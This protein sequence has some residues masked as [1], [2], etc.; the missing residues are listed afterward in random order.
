MGCRIQ[1]ALDLADMEQA[2][3]IAQVVSSFVDILEA[4]TPL[5]KSVGLEVVRRLRAAHPDKLIVADMKSTDV[6]AF[7]ADLAFRAG[8]D[9]TVACGLTSLATIEAVQREAERW[10]RACMV[11]LTGVEDLLARCRALSDRGVEYVVVHRSVDEETMKGALWTERMVEEITDLCDMGMKVLVA[12]G[13]GPDNVVCFRGVPIYG[14]IV[15][16][17]ITAQPDPAAAAAAVASGI[18]GLEA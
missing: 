14:V 15:G 13:L 17:G 7:E 18:K 2:L 3:Q 6:G 5:I 1:V 10:G 4:G 8:A 16:R 11:D 12:G 9:F